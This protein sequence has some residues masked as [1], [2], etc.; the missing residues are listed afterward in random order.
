MFQIEFLTNLE[1]R[2]VI[3]RNT[4]FI[5]EFFREIV[6]RQIEADFCVCIEFRL[7]S[8]NLVLITSQSYRMNG[9][10]AVVP[11][12]SLSVLSDYKAINYAPI[13]NHADNCSMSNEYSTPMHMFIYSLRTDIDR[14]R[15]SLVAGHSIGL[16]G[17]CIRTNRQSFHRQYADLSRSSVR[18]SIRQHSAPSFIVERVNVD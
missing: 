15:R 13:A 8:E 3:G 6:R 18:I 16:D 7:I 2:E 14:L 4:A 5:T 10:D 12:C 9:S 11:S 1:K 17:Q